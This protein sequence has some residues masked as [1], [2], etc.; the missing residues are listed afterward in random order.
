MNDPTK[1]G[2]EVL[3]VLDPNFGERLRDEWHGQGVWIT[4]SPVNAVTVRSLWA[5]APSQNHLTGITGFTHE[6]DATAEDRLL[7]HLSDIDLHHGPYSTKS[8]YTALAVIGTPLS[9]NIR[10]ALSQLGFLEFKERRDGFV[11]NRSKEEASFAG[12]LAHLR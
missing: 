2:R 12:G 4:M 6:K 9:D 3:V 1:S 10:T 8:P 5:T 11:A 7:A